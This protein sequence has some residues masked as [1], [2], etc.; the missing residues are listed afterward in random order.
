MTKIQALIEILKDLDDATLIDDLLIYLVSRRKDL[1]VNLDRICCRVDGGSSKGIVLKP[2]GKFRPHPVNVVHRSNDVRAI[3][4]NKLVK[5][6]TGWDNGLILFGPRTKKKGKTSM[7]FSFQGEGQGASVGIVLARTFPTTGFVNKTKKGWAYFQDTGCI[8]HGGPATIPY[9]VGFG[10]SGDV[11]DVELNSSDGTLGF[12]SNGEYQGVAFDDIPQ[13]ADFFFAV[14][15]MEEGSIV[16]VYD[17][18]ILNPCIECILMILNRRRARETAQKELR[19]DLKKFGIGTTTET[20][21]TMTVLDYLH[22]IEDNSL[23][24]NIL[25]FV[26][27]ERVNVGVWLSQNFDNDGVL[28]DFVPVAKVVEGDEYLRIG[29]DH[30]VLIRQRSLWD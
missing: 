20:I 23:L 17:N 9:G 5:L 13:D 25:S 12:Y 4:T 7:S 19:E 21:N 29:N 3:E 30:D 15:L 16:E 26:V 27:C 22:K 18:Y 14:S 2:E 8:G 10:E 6:K 24:W 28:P 11:V 1:N